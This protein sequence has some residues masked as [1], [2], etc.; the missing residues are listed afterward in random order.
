MKIHRKAFLLLSLISLIAAPTAYSME[1]VTLAKNSADSLQNIPSNN[2]ASN[3]DSA[4]SLITP[5]K[6]LEPITINPSDM[7]YLEGIS[8][9]S[10]FALELTQENIGEPEAHGIQVSLFQL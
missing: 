10:D 5:F 3:F 7:P 1:S 2:L 8:T 9:N 4:S 6:T